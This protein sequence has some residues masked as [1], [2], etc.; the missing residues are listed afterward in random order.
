MSVAAIEPCSCCS[1]A[2]AA[3]RR[4]CRRAV[5]ARSLST[6]P[7]RFCFDPFLPLLLRPRLLPFFSGIASAV[8]PLDRRVC[9]QDRVHKRAPCSPKLPVRR[10]TRPKFSNFQV[11]Q[12]RAARP[13]ASLLVHKLA[14]AAYPRRGARTSMTRR[15]AARLARERTRPRLGALR[16]AKEDRSRPL[17]HE[18]YSADSQTPA[19]RAQQVGSSSHRTN[20]GCTKCADLI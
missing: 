2:S 19:A 11:P 15:S 14:A 16:V 3:L 12:P 6:P 4:C 10:T 5:S 18:R 9:V 20:G 17:T 7:L 8:G 13:S 1:S